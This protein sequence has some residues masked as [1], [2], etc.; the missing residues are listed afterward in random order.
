MKSIKKTIIAVAFFGG[1]LS[2]TSCGTISCWAY[3]DNADEKIEKQDIQE[4]TQDWAAATF[5]SEHPSS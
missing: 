3:A 4:E 2:M 1:A 5:V